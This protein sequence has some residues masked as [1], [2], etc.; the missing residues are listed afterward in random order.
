M[1]MVTFN[2]KISVEDLESLRELASE[3]ERTVAGEVRVAVKDRLA[4]QRRGRD[5]AGKGAR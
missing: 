1:E 3:N 2:I 4:A 5:A